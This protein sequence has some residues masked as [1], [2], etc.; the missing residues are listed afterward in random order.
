MIVPFVLGDA[1]LRSINHVSEGTRFFGWLGL[2]AAILTV[3]GMAFYTDFHIVAV[4][5]NP[6]ARARDVLGAIWSAPLD[7]V[8]AVANWKTVA[9]VGLAGFASMLLGY[10][11]DDPYPN[12]GAVQRTYYSARDARED[13][14]ARLRKRVNGLIDAAELEI[15][16][17]ETD[18]RKKVSAY[19]R[20]VEK[21]KHVPGALKNYDAE[22]EDACNMVLDRY[23]VANLAARETDAPMS[24]SEHVCFNPDD[25]MEAGRLLDNNSH[26][27]ELQNALAELENE[28][29]LARKNLRAL[30]LRT[31]ESIAGSQ[32][33]EED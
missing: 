3:A 4:L 21:S 14:S 5:E 27:A 16:T 7:A 26:V 8:T 30:N 22:L 32:P 10:R 28:A 20:L 24:F 25:E 33:V 15:E 19:N 13:L 29:N 1:W 31:I 17:L 12:Y 9:L 18:F 2:I 6:E 23:R 11:S